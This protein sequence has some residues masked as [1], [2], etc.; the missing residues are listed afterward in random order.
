MKKISSHPLIR[1]ITG[2]AA[3]HK[4]IASIAAIIIIFLGYSGVQAL[5]GT[6]TT[7]RYVT[8]TVANDTLISSVPGTGQIS[9]LN[10][11]DLKAKASG[12][13]TYIPVTQGQFVKAGT[14]IA[15]LDQTDAQKAVRDA[16][17]SLQ[18]AQLSLQKLTQPADTLSL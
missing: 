17:I 18:S 1:K 8:T 4:V 11:V 6:P 15:G 9:A 2:Y 5:R 12:N 14:V 10:Q 16:E 3:A 13:V 7:T